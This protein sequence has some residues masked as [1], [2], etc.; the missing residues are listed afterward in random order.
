L[1]APPTAV[2][3]TVSK[4]TQTT[5]PTQGGD[6]ELHERLFELEE[7]FWNGDAGY[8]DEHLAEECIMVFAPPVGDRRARGHHPVHRGQRELGRGAPHDAR[9]AGA[10]RRARRC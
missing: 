1:T 4:A 9:A 7:G 8:Y 2:P 5:T 3:G 6:V 10:R